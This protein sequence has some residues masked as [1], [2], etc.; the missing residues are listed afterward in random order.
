MLFSTGNFRSPESKRATREARAQKEGAAMVN[1]LL[2]HCGYNLEAEPAAEFHGARTVIVD[3]LPK[4]PI[5]RTL[6]DSLE[7]S[8]VEGIE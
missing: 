2:R 5:V 6:I 7:L 3:Y 4:V 1:P 8:V